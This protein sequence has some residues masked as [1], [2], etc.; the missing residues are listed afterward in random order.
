M[1][2]R[3]SWS[4]R[5]RLKN[6]GD[7]TRLRNNVPRMNSTYAA[8]VLYCTE[9]KTQNNQCICLLSFPKSHNRL[10]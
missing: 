5:D 9:M 6:N 1:N 4:V 2:D 7:E 10:S 3:Q 8:V